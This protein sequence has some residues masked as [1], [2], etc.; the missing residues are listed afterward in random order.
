MNRTTITRFLR[1]L[2]IS[3][4]NKGLKIIKKPFVNLNPPL[5]KMVSIQ[6]ISSN[7]GFF[8]GLKPGPFFG[9][10]FQE[11]IIPIFMELREN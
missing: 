2:K 7:R 5:M 4:G 3:A 9:I 1:N 8:N 11:L 10:W 6:L